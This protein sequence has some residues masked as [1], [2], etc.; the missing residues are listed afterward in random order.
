MEAAK[1]PAGIAFRCDFE[2]KIEQIIYDELGL[3]AEF[4]PGQSL[5]TLVDRA[6][7]QKTLS[8]LLELRTQG[9]AFD[10]E[11]NVSVAGQL[12]T[13]H[14][15]GGLIDEKLLIIVAKSRNGVLQMYEDIMRIS[16]E[17]VNA[18][19]A[20]TKEQVALT[21]SQTERDHTLYNEISRLNNELVTLQRELAKKNAE[22]EAL[23]RELQRLNELK[24]TFLGM[25]AHDLR[26]P[27]ANIKM[28]AGFLLDSTDSHLPEDYRQLLDDIASQSRYM[29]VLVADLLDVTQI[30]T[31]KLELNRIPVEVADF[32]AQAVQRQAQIATTKGTGVVLRP[33]PAGRMWA[34][35]FRL[36]QV[37]DN[38]ISNAV[39][40]SPPGSTVSVSA[41]PAP[42]HWRI[43]VADE[44]PSITE[45]DRQYLFQDF[46]RL[47]ARPTG[48]EAS[49]GLGLA[50]SRRVVEAHGGQIGVDTE[51]GQGSNFWFTVPH[52]QVA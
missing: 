36:R 31:G 34:D 11:L 48:G 23:N 50:I 27:L 18:L 20:V 40:F 38:L 42:G 29:L 51:P 30:E 21:R 25:A 46:A 39:K 43:N 41:D 6:S 14:F 33:V 26:G 49:T 8:F 2:G 32:L 5:T 10:W 9:A 7:F 3:A 22:Q 24:N 44:G 16:N 15:G 17:Q 13:L 37:I 45:E 52:S 19:R 28:A 4:S 12:A 35:P 1:K 47:S